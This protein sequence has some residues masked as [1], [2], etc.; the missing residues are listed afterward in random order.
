MLPSFSHKPC[1]TIAPYSIFISLH[2]LSPRIFCHICPQTSVSK[3]TYRN[4]KPKIANCFQLLTSGFSNL[5]QRIPH[6]F[7]FD[8]G[9]SPNMQHPPT[10]IKTCDTALSSWYSR[11][12]IIQAINLL[13]STHTSA[14][15]SFHVLYRYINA[16]SNFMKLS[17]WFNVSKI[18]RIL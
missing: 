7:N 11:G 13:Q 2:P 8:C 16:P 5:V 9:H 17:I 18:S 4:L 15:V 12:Q 3:P 1:V 14:F 6:V 10:V